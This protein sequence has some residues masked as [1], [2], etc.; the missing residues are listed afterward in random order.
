MAFNRNFKKQFPKSLPV[1]GN[2]LAIIS[3]IQN[4]PPSILN[5]AQMIGI[6]RQNLEKI[7]G[8]TDNNHIDY[9]QLIK[10][11]SITLENYPDGNLPEQLNQHIN[12]LQTRFLDSP[13]DNN[14]LASY[15]DLI[16]TPEPVQMIVHNYDYNENYQ[17][18]NE[19]YQEHDDN[20]Q[21]QHQITL[22]NVLESDIKDDVC[23]ICLVHLRDE[24][25]CSVICNHQ[26]HLGCLQTWLQVGNKCPLCNQQL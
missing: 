19:N 23:I 1:F 10:N 5:A 21:E 6:N 24:P 8:S 2:V 18:Y 11:L 17:D 3:E 20:Y 22:T 12:Q 9:Y 16:R 4:I 14:N 7:I 26:Y 25:V 13:V 15:F